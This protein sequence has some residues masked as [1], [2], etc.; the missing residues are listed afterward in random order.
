M[1]GQ[2]YPLTQIGVLCLA[3]RL[4]AVAETDIKYGECTARF[5]EHAKIN[6]RPCRC[7]EVVHPKPRRNF[8][9]HIA[10]VFIDE[11]LNIPIR[12]ECYGWPSGHDKRPPLMEEYTYL[13]F[14]LNAGLSAEDFDVENPE[15]G[16]HLETRE[17]ATKG[18]PAVIAKTSAP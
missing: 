15:Y 14:K 3:K 4:I 13:D 5:I 8:L 16:F 10:R 9:F 11:K 1:Q 7:I 17:V 6:G 2:K 18:E 12:Y